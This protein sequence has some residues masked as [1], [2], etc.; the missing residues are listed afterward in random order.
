MTTTTKPAT[1][2]KASP[3]ATSWHAIERPPAKRWWW[4]T[5]FTYTC[6]LITVLLIGLGQ[7]IA[8]ALTTVIAVAVA[9]FSVYLGKPR[10]VHARLTST[11]LYVN[12]QRFPL[13]DYRSYRTDDNALIL[14]PRRLARLR[15]L[16][17][18]TG[19]SEID[20]D[21]LNAL[22][23]RLPYDETSTTLVDRLATWLR[24]S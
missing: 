21:I 5:G 3:P 24:L 1:K 10:P 17:P 23:I 4:F 15:V 7:W 14:V 6:F 11:S 16:V 19:D 8:A 13:K 9:V 2:K 18:L 12:D 20:T 22:G